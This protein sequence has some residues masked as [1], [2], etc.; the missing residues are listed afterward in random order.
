M[1]LSGSRL[2]E[3]ILTPNPAPEFTAVTDMDTVRELYGS[4]RETILADLIGSHPN[5]WSP[6]ADVWVKRGHCGETRDLS[7]RSH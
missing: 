1:Q 5:K 4:W 2:P 6:D 7:Y 3:A